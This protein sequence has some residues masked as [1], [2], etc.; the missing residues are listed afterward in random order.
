M[1]KCLCSQFRDTYNSIIRRRACVYAVYLCS[2]VPLSIVPSLG[3]HWFSSS[4]NSEACFSNGCATGVLGIAGD[5]QLS[6]AALAVQLCRTFRFGILTILWLCQPFVWMWFPAWV[7]AV[8]DMCSVFENEIF[9]ISCHC[10]NYHCLV[11][12]LQCPHNDTMSTHGFVQWSTRLTY[13]VSRV[14]VWIWMLEFCFD[15]IL[16][17]YFSCVPMFSLCTDILAVFR[18]FHCVP[19]F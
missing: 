19:I 12:F 6:N 10:R 9:S 4:A 16:Y 5:V 2:Q 14:C 15:F 3:P 8:C 17:R 1:P 11:S 7:S 13:N 18:C